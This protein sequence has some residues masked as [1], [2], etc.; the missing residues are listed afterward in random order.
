[1]KSTE[2]LG[3]NLYEAADYVLHDSFNSDNQ[4]LDAAIMDAHS[5]HKL[6]ELAA[7]TAGNSVSFDLSDIDWSQWQAVHLD[8]LALVDGTN[9][10]SFDLYFNGD[11]STYNTYWRL[12][13]DHG[14]GCTMGK[15][16]ANAGESR[17]WADRIRMLVGRC[18]ERLIRTVTSDG[19]GK[20]E[21][22]RYSQLETLHLQAPTASVLNVLAGTRLVIWGEK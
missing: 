15:V 13:L 7:S 2:N 4:K 8:F 14:D 1:M 16:L 12:G 10:T 17:V 21:N 3:L 5:F 9:N 11:A 19:C 6:K 20:H 22:L 18:P